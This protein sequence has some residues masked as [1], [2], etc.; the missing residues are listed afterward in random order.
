MSE[1]S[2][3]GMGKFMFRKGRFRLFLERNKWLKKVPNTLTI[4]NSLCGFGAIL[5]ALHVYDSPKMPED[6][7]AI[8]AWV[9]LFAMVFDVLDGFAARI[10]NA[11]SIH[12]LQMDSLSDMVTFGMAPAVIVAV[13]AHSM[14]EMKPYQ[15]FIVWAFCAIY[16][17]CAASRLADYNVHAMLEKKNTAKFKGLPSPGAAAGICSLVIFYSSK[18]G[19][20][21]QILTILPIYAALLGLLM[22]SNVPYTHIGKWLLS[23]RRNKKRLFVLFVVLVSMLYW[24]VLVLV[25][26]INIYILS[27][28]VL[29]F[30]EKAGLITLPAEPI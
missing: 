18:H 8:S 9:V 2:V 5:Y 10:L 22:V 27:G 1:S 19:E 30:A 23:V 24:P 4:C 14:R 3:K 7:L 17:G 16:I 21:Q 26:V 13:A 11:A 12:G 15:Y 28:A 25:L 6:V 29:Y 20:I